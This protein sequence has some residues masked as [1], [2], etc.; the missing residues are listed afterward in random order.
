M[1]LRLSFIC[2][3]FLSHI[4]FLECGRFKNGCGPQLYT[5]YFGGR[6]FLPHESTFTPACNKHDS[7]FDCVSSVYNIF[8][9]H[10]ENSF[11]KNSQLKKIINNFL[12][13]FWY[14]CNS[15]QKPPL[16]FTN[17]EIYLAE[18]WHKA[19]WKTKPEYDFTSL[20]FNKELISVAQIALA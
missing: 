11:K 19:I 18:I 4:N 9:F 14:F 8:L 3:L 17:F 7:C 2:S 5:Q 13:K 15:Q 16:K 10:C 6:N 12:S 20:W 1:G